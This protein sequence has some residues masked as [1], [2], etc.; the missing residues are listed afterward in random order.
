MFEFKKEYETGIPEVDREHR[1]FVSYI[2]K[3]TAALD[4]DEENGIKAA[5][6]LL[7]VLVSY[8][9][10]HFAH[11]EHYMRMT[12][13]PLL[14]EQIKAHQGFKDALG[15]LIARRDDMTIKGLGE[16]FIFMTK[17]LKEHIVVEDKKIQ[18]K[19]V[20]MRMTD[21]FLVGVDLIDKEH[22]NLFDIVGRAHDMVYGTVVSDRFDAIIAI[23][24]ELKDY[25]IMHFADE[26]RYME[27]IEYKGLAAQKKAHEAFLDKVHDID[28][29]SLPED[30]DEQSI[31]LTEIVNFLTDWLVDHILKM[32]KLIPSA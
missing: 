3:A 6:A 11:E 21:E 1:M 16:I 8:A 26:E 13:S 22:T 30:S 10:T 2:N 18:K 31:I 12:D 14:D 23:V 4:M 24:E 20:K 25:T 17:W 28:V 19:P 7:D 9:D 5:H 32:D 27:K 29:S 15:E